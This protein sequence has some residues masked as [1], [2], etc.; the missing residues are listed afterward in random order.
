MQFN[1]TVW[2]CCERSAARFERVRLRAE[3]ERIGGMRESTRKRLENE[4]FVA[5]APEAV[6]QKEREKLE[7][8]AEQE[9]K[10]S[11]TL[12]ALEGAA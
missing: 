2:I 1:S 11:R 5:R 9:E 10:L 7:S 12:R 6:V 4:G 3:L 8:L